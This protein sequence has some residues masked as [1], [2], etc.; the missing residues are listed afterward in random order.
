M[1]VHLSPHN[2]DWLLQFA[3]T[4]SKLE[5]ILI[6]IPIRSIEHVG[7]TSIPNLLAKPVLDIDI[8][9]PLSSLPAV[10][11]ALSNTGYTDCGEMNVPGRFAFREPG[12]SAKQAAFGGP[13]AEGGRVRENTYAMIEG[14]TALRNHLD[15]KRVLLEDEGLRE[16]YARTKEKL[17]EVDVENIG[18]YVFGKSKILEKMLKQAG[19]TDEDLE[20]V[21][22]ANRLD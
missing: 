19:W 14:C 15:V 7:S 16:E 20:P 4:K 10:R 8:I 22:E 13:P 18:V 2:P 12:F 9:I 1:K 17:T 21:R 11:S 6:D 3:S 5:S